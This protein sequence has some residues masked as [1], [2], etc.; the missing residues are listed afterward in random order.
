MKNYQFDETKKKNRLIP[1]TYE[2]HLKVALQKY[3]A[4][5]VMIDQLIVLKNVSVREGRKAMTVSQMI[6]LS[7]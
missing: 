6:K 7:F 5:N 1:T 3:R 4:L 2:H